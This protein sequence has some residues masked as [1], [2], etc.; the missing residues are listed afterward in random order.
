VQS[1]Y[2]TTPWTR[3]S[4]GA[5]VADGAVRVAT[6]RS[7]GRQS[8]R[9]GPTAARCR[10]TRRDQDETGG[11]TDSTA[12]NATAGNQNSRCL[13]S[14]DTN[15]RVRPGKRASREPI[16]PCSISRQR[17]VKRTRSRT[18]A[19]CSSSSRSSSDSA[20]VRSRTLLHPPSGIGISI[21][22][23]RVYG[24]I[25]ARASA[26]R[27]AVACRRTPSRAVAD[28]TRERVDLE[29]R[30]EQGCRRAYAHRRVN[31]PRI[32]GGSTS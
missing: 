27:R 23:G 15:V 10:S 21:A 26:D 8:Y 31:R 25:A 7:A 18:T 12:A 22:V 20:L 1:W 14:R 4:R 11:W 19:A 5:G 9:S 2:T 13:A 29:E 32:P 6:T 17:S 28:G 24:A 3:N 16:R 30:L